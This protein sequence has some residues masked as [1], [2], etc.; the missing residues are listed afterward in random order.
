MK[1]P[2]DP[3]EFAEWVESAATRSLDPAK[4]LDEALPGATR[5]PDPQSVSPFGGPD[6][7][8]KFSHLLD[9]GH[10]VVVRH[11]QTGEMQRGKITNFG[12]GNMV[13]V[14][15]DSGHYVTCLASELTPEDFPEGEGAPEKI[16][17]N[18]DEPAPTRA[19]PDSSVWADPF[20]GE[21]RRSATGA[22]DALEKRARFRIGE[23]VK[24]KRGGRV[25]TVISVSGEMI[26]IRFG[27]GQTGLRW[28][29][30]IEAE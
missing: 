26:E 4:F 3:L 8:G 30:Q 7:L 19:T 13:Y 27:K 28:S 29:G 21:D 5:S 24:E 22:A 9:I 15:L 23:S 16:A 18:A 14:Q 25:G 12:T 20:G 1:L 6:E 2:L 10:R 11:Q 17:K